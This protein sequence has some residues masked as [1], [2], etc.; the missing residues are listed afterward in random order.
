MVNFIEMTD[1]E[2]QKCKD[3][4]IADY[5]AERVK[6]GNED[7]DPEASR[8]EFESLLPQG[9]RTKDHYIYFIADENEKDRKVGIIWYTTEAENQPKGT[10]FIY[11]IEVEQGLRGRGYGRAALRL[12]E[13]RAKETG[14]R[15]I[16]LHVFG[17]NVR[18]R[19]LY[20]DLG[21]RAT[22]VIMAKELQSPAHGAGS[23]I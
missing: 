4:A 23:G 15:R 19:K 11:D 14:M 10:M 22:N 21:Y 17:H 3:R 1:E 8:R 16:A 12:L 18:A 13:D 7:Q 9:R 2:F 20:E 6:A 5:F